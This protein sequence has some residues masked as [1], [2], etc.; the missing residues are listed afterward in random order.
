MTDRLYFFLEET[1]DMLGRRLYGSEWTGNELI[2]VTV[3]SPQAIEEKAA[4][5]VQAIADANAEIVAAQDEIAS[6]VD[7]AKVETLTARITDLENRR[8]QLHSEQNDLPLLT[9]SYTTSYELF[10]RHRVTEEHLIGALA[11]GAMRAWAMRGDNGTGIH[12]RFWRGEKG[13]AYYLDLSLVVLPL[14]EYGKRRGTAKI[15]ITDFNAWLESVTPITEDAIAKLSVEEQATA[16]FKQEVA[17]NQNKSPGRKN[18]VPRMQEL[19]PGLSERAALQIWQQH[20]P[21][22]W[23]EPGRRPGS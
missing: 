13:F 6:T 17:A 18:I 16:W 4:P 21:E 5:L 1:F 20:A 2:A 8:G 12:A 22:Q 11:S 19:F 14:T 15:R 3:E 23:K 7:A 10:E 9:E